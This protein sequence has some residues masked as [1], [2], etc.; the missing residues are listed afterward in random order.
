MIGDLRRHPP[1]AL[2]RRQ[3]SPPISPCPSVMMSINA[4]R[5]KLN[6]IARRRS[7]LWKGAAP[8]LTIIV[9]LTLV[10]VT[11]Q[12]ACG[13]WLLKSFK[14]GTVTPKGEITS[15]LPAKNARLRADISS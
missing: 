13:V 1:H 7:G 12:I 6:A 10:A 5:S 14:V 4:L 15:N 11:S 3:H 9:R 8:E 2:R